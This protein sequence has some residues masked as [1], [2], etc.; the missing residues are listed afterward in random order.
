[1]WR[2]TSPLLRGWISPDATDADESWDLIFLFGTIRLVL[3]PGNFSS[4]GSGDGRDARPNHR[5]FLIEDAAAWTLVFPH[6]RR[7]SSDPGVALLKSRFL[8]L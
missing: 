8:G 5:H 4:G 3:E 1:M 6:R 7:S 2:S